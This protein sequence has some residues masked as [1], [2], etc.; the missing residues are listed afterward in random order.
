MAGMLALRQT[1]RPRV[2]SLLLTVSIA[3]L[4]L[5]STEAALRASLE[6]EHVRHRRSR[7][8]PRRRRQSHRATDRNVPGPDRA[9]PRAAHSTRRGARKSGFPADDG[10]EVA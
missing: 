10:A 2:A 6:D 4:A 9:R 7:Y 5:E 8:T 3:S 1:G